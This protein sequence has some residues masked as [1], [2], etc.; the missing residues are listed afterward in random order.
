M[1][2]FLVSETNLF[3]CH[4]A[5]L[6]EQAKSIGATY[7]ASPVFGRPP[8]AEAAKLLVVLS[9]PADVKSEIKK[10]LIPAIGDR[11]VDVGEDVKLGMSFCRGLRK[12]C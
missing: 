12:T 4:Q 11:F 6:A 7:I 3:F 10:H 1:S 5:K 2:F 8:A 9:G